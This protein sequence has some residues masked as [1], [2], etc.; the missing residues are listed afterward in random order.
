M[1]K[2]NQAIL[3]QQRTNCLSVFDHLVGLALK[4][5]ITF[6]W[7]SLVFGGT[8]SVWCRCLAIRKAWIFFVIFTFLKMIKEQSLCA[9]ILSVTT[10][11]RENWYYNIWNQYGK[12]F[13][14][15]NE[16]QFQRQLTEPASKQ[17]VLRNTYTWKKNISNSF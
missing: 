17:T 10:S 16:I 4:G 15:Y 8:Y 2:H 1:V 12:S 6:F 11:V 9:K 7:N 13:P 14:R 3:R 5:L